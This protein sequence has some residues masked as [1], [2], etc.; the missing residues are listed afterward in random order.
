MTEKEMQE[1]LDQDLRYILERP[2]G[3][4]FIWRLIDEEAL[5]H[6]QSYSGEATH[7]TAFA[8]GRRYVG[9]RLVDECKRVAP[10]LFLRMNA[11]AI[12]RAS[13]MVAE[14]QRK[15]QEEGG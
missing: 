8:E 11:E 5:V 14:A 7:A 9:L 6:A 3:R 10:Q 13:D 2:E 1:A 12:D 4:R 15:A